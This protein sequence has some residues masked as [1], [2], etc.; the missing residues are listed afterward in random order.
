MKF[1]SSSFYIWAVGVGAVIG[2]HFVGWNPILQ[3]GYGGALIA[4]ILGTI[5]YTLLT[6]MVAELASWFPKAGGAHVYALEGYGNFA[7]F[8]VGIAEVIKTTSTAAAIV[9]GISD[10]ITDALGIN[11]SYYGPLNYALIMGVLMSIN[12]L[13]VRVTFTFQ[14]V[15]LVLSLA[16][17]FIYFAGAM[18]YLDF[19][20]YA[21]PDGWFPYG[22]KGIMDGF[23]FVLWLFL[24]VEEVAQA[25]EEVENPAVDIPRGASW[26]MVTLAVLGVGLVTLASAT[27]PGLDALKDSDVPLLDSYQGIY[28]SGSSMLDALDILVLSGLVCS[29][30]AFVFFS[31]EVVYA[32]SRDGFLPAP[33][34]SVSQRFHTPYNALFVSCSMVFLLALIFDE[35]VGAEMGLPVLVS[36]AADSAVLSYGFQIA[37]YLKLHDSLQGNQRAF[38]SPFG[39]WGGYVTVPILAGICLCLV[40]LAVT[41]VQYALGLGLVVG[42][43]ALSSLCYYFSR[44]FKYTKLPDNAPVKSTP[45][46]SEDDMGHRLS[47]E[48][49]SSTSEDYEEDGV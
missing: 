31:G 46:L 8:L 18:F 24:G 4:T 29:L 25:V 10:Y 20:K 27:P 47:K 37:I 6:F 43:L 45:R 30:H 16:V 28:G 13:G 22:W 9:S 21:V 38:R 33:L 17:L 23:P 39:K 1:S 40:Y 11:Q 15:I 36:V 5:F 49:C 19:E 7:G 14:V 42:L 26:A 48:P 3:M 12:L 41:E 34:S 2:G 35:I 32:L 44:R